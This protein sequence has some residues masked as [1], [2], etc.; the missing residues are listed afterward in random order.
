[1]TD[2]A[3]LR[4]RVLGEI[5]AAPDP[6]R[7]TTGSAST[8][9]T[10]T[11]WCSARSSGKPSPHTRIPLGRGI[12]GAA[13]AEQATIIVDD[14]HADPR[15]LACSPDT[16]SEIVVP[17]MREGT[18]CSASST[19]TAT[20]PA[21]FGPPDRELLEA[22]A[23]AGAEAV[24]SEHGAS[25]HPDPGR[26]HRSRSHRGGSPDFQGGRA[27]IEWERHDAGVIAFER[28]KRRCRWSCSTRSH[29]NKVALKGPVTTPIAEGITSVNVGLRKALICTPTSAPCGTCR[30]SRAG[31]RTSTSSSCARTPRICTRASS[32]RWCPASSRA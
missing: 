9:S 12:C 17:I 23:A 25:D 30:A 27:D 14:V 3:A 1:M 24:G 31:S 10:A 20:G 26:R 11:S 19:W 29:R 15:Y 16:R 22:V 2:L 21:A 8:C 6:C 13:A 28:F 5:A 18:K 4:D 7:T 32:T